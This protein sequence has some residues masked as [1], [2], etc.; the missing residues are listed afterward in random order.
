MEVRLADA[1]RRGKVIAEQ[2]GT[3]LLE[4]DYHELSAVPVDEVRVLLGIPPK[5]VEARGAGSP[6][7]FD[8][9]GMSEFQRAAGQRH[10]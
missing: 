4:V 1:I 9:G 3:D 7:T 5:S 8:P 10:A 2:Y 6:G